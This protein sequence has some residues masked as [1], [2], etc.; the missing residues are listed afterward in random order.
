[1][2]FQLFWVSTPRKKN[3]KKIV[4]AFCR[5]GWWGVRPSVEFSTLLFFIFIALIS[6]STI[7]QTDGQGRMCFSILFPFPLAHVLFKIVQFYI[8]NIDLYSVSQHGCSRYRRTSYTYR[9]DTPH[10]FIYSNCRTFT[11]LIKKPPF[12]TRDILS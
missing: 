2:F 7:L 8:N 6:Y 1:M 11:L 4:H 10:N 3:L 12:I 9:K 5:R